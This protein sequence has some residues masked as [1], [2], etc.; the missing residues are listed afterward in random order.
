M[1]YSHRINSYQIRDTPSFDIIFVFIFVFMW[2]LFGW[3]TG[4]ADYNNYNYIYNF[5]D[6]SGDYPAVE[7]GFKWIVKICILLGLN[8][9]GFL[10]TY[11][12][13]G[14]M[15]IT[16]TAKKF[17]NNTTLVLVLYF[18]YPFLLDV[19][20]IRNFLSM[21]LMV[22]ATRYL[23]QDGWKGVLKYILLI[24]IATTFH[25]SSIFYLLFLLTKIKSYKKITII[26]LLSIF[27]GYAAYNFLT[28]FIIR[29]LS[30]DRYTTYFSESTSLYAKIL[31]VFYFAFSL[32]LMF[33]VYKRIKRGKY[34]QLSSSSNSDQIQYADIVFKINIL[35]LISYIFV[36]KDVDFVRLYRNILPL[37]FILFAMIKPKYKIIKNVEMLVHSWLFVAFLGFSSWAFIYIRTFD[38]VVYPIFTNNSIFELFK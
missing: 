12:F 22:F 33:Y 11:S 34:Q 5:I 19:V 37:N 23:I 36:I 35:I 4:N 18:V 24:L 17:T 16:S 30:M 14:L 1:R 6:A 26:T 20:Q 10:I 3:N 2:I 27:F 29:F 7:V 13:I 28:V 8:Y 21:A 38:T 31:F 9:N 15:L 32:I 25:Y